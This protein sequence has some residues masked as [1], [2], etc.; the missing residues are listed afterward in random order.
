MCILEY[1]DI[2]N[3]RGSIHTFVSSTEHFLW[4]KWSLRY[5]DFKLD[6][7]F[8]GLTLYVRP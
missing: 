5:L 1:C 2:Y 3:R 8:F 4:D 6:G 7:L